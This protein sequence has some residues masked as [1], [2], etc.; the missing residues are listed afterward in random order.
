MEG[1][2]VAGSRGWGVEGIG[3]RGWGDSCLCHTFPALRISMVSFPSSDD[4]FNPCCTDLTSLALELSLWGDVGGS[5]LSWLDRPPLERMEGARELLMEVGAIDDKGK[6]TDRGR[7]MGRIGTHPRFANLILLG[8]SPEIGAPELS[9]LLAAMLSEKDVLSSSSNQGQPA[10]ADVTLRIQALIQLSKFMDSPG[11]LASTIGIST[12]KR[13]IETTLAFLNQVRRG[14]DADVEESDTDEEEQM[15]KDEG[16]GEGSED[17]QRSNKNKP[18][19]S[20]NST[21]LHEALKAQMEKNGLTG[22]LIALCYPD[23]IAKRKD[24]TSFTMADARTVGLRSSDPLSN[25]TSPY[26]SIAELSG[27]GG[28]KYSGRNDQI[29]IAAPLSNE[30]V[31]TWLEPLM[32]IRRVAIWATAS[33][34]VI[35]REQARLGALVL[36]EKSVSVTDEEAKAPLLRGFKEMNALASFN[37]DKELEAFRSRVSWLRSN[38]KGLGSSLP[39]LSNEG[40]IATSPT[41]LFNYASG[42]R[43]KADLASLDWKTILEEMMGGR[44]AAMRVNERM[45]VSFECPTGT[46]VLIDYSRGNP[47]A[48]VRIQEVFGLSSSPLVGDGIPVVL[49][50][51]S[52]GQKPIQTTADLKGFWQSSYQLVKAEMKGRYPRHIWPDHPDTAEATRLSKAAF[53]RLKEAE[54]LEQATSTQKDKSSGGG[55]VVKKKGKK[56]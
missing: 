48:S 42:A 36:S 5:S 44:Q 8:S 51:L 29:R 19:S 53:A 56:K 25:S 46:K 6:P 14:D 7:R 1:E 45:P 55:E 16:E 18:S 11:H 26:L 33:K 3:S 21:P 47:T 37:L 50:L 54:E 17:R 35:G 22:A 12:G 15:D 10:T 38:D 49:E 27:K 40:L 32:R 4:Q 20:S 23:R 30:A 43:S 31:S 2:W 13:V 39:D 9:C 28:D 34:A 52:P 41:W 24:R